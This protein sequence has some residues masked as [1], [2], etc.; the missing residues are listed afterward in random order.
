MGQLAHM[1]ELAKERDAMR[2]EGKWDPAVMTAIRSKLG[3]L[4]NALSMEDGAYH[5][6]GDVLYGKGAARKASED[7][8]VMVLEAYVKGEGG[9]DVEG[10]KK[11]AEELGVISN[12]PPKKSF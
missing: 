10:M 5:I 6:L 12:P 8:L 7:M 2:P 11:K 3:K 9:K 4:V 1:A